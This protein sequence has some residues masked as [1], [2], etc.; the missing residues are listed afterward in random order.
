MESLYC[1]TN[2]IRKHI[3]NNTLEK[4]NFPVN[5][6]IGEI[7]KLLSSIIQDMSQGHIMIDDNNSNVVICHKNYKM[8]YYND[9]CKF[10]VDKILIF[11]KMYSDKVSSDII[12]DF[13]N[14]KLIKVLTYQF[15]G[16]T[17]LTK[18]NHLIEMNNYNIENML[19]AASTNGT[20]PTLLFWYDKLKDKDVFM[21][22]IM[23]YF[24]NSVGNSDD[25]IFK[26]LLKL[27]PKDKEFNISNVMNK[28]VS[29]LVPTKYIL[30][31]IKLFSSY[32][33]LSEHFETMIIIFTDIKIICELHKYYYKSYQYNMTIMEQLILN[34]YYKVQNTDILHNIRNV[35]NTEEE[36]ILFDII[37]SLKIDN[38][39]EFYKNIIINNNKLFE[40][41]VI[42][43]YTCIIDTI[44]WKK[45]VEMLD[46]NINKT[47]LKVL[48]KNDLISKYINDDIYNIL[49][50]DLNML[51]HTKYL[52]INNDTMSQN[53]YNPNTLLKYNNKILAINKILYYIRIFIR[54]RYN[55]KI[56]N[57]KIKTFNLIK[58]IKTFTPNNMVKILNR[59]S[60]LFQYDKQKFT[61]LP[62]RHL[63]PKELP[64]YNNFLLRE[65]ADGILVNNIPNDIYPYNDLITN[66]SIKAEYIEDLDL[67]LIFDIDIPNTMI[68]E[69]YEILRNAHPYT[70]H[71]KLQYCETLDDFY[72]IMDDE[73]QNIKKFLDTNTNSIIK[74]YP[75]FA[76]EIYN[77]FYNS[78][79]NDVIILG[80][81]KLLECE[82]YNCDGLILSPL[83]SNTSMREI[84]IKPLSLCS[85]DLLY[86]N[87]LW[88]DSNNNDWSHIIESNNIK[89]K[90]NKI[91]RC[92]PISSSWEKFR[93]DSMRYDKKKPNSYNIIDCIINIL[94]YDWNNDNIVDCNYYY[95]NVKNTIKDDKLI[96]ILNN[97]T[98]IFNSLLLKLYPMNNKN[99]LDLGCGSGKHINNIKKYMPKNYLGLDIDIKQLIK[100]LTYNDMNQDV[101]RFIPCD[102][103]ND[104]SSFYIKWA[105]IKTNI[106]Y[107]YIIANFSLMHFCN[108]IFWSQL[109]NITTDNSMFMFNIV[110]INKNNNTSWKYKE[111]Y[112]D[113]NNSETRYKFLWSH[114]MEKVESFI[115]KDT[116]ERYLMKY[117]WR[118]I[119]CIQNNSDE[120]DGY[121]SWY[122]VK[123]N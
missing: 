93:V 73:R 8:N 2:I 116:I 49:K 36:K 66:Y 106:K 64:S 56:I 101:Y 33:N 58:E 77:N 12:Y 18:I 57:H 38:E 81:K 1:E 47:I 44:N 59:G 109:N 103:S 105:S 92:Y 108:D 10:I 52:T 122:I 78:I 54:K 13:I 42:A 96:T 98:K 27:I 51:L 3:K 53:K 74:W 97:Q 67:F 62:P 30:R 20:L 112:L 4:Y 43:N 119:E 86:S 118:I 99:W 15:K 14:S 95:D 7:I 113:I 35:L 115:S 25:R 84:K 19:I 29:S 9:T 26:Y 28:L 76:A 102:L 88:L 107:D 39:L 63:L 50:I 16:Q 5:I 37:Y 79:I 11:N 82:T 123:K 55:N 61:N 45:F 41:I 83:Q 68:K 117:N 22:N 23:E 91:Y 104:W 24:Y 21:N 120:L 100:A 80:N 48:V 89:L 94:K 85:I 60:L 70:K 6:T 111:S 110:S 17:F 69:R 40:N 31:R 34:I 90:D 65:K 87:N 114:K 75:K 121:Y 46:Y 71:T 72:K 32:V